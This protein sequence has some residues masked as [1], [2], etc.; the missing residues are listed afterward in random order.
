MN[1]TIQ[2]LEAKDSDFTEAKF[3][4]KVENEFVQIKLSTVTGK[5]EKVKH[6]VN[7]EIYN[8]IVA[9][10]EEDK[11]QN[12]IQLYEELNV[13]N[14][15]IIN[16]EEQEDCFTIEVRLLSKAYEYYINRETKKY[17]SGNTEERAEKFNKLIFTK[18][19]KA[20][21]FEAARKCP[22]CGAN[23]DVNKDGKCSYC[24]SIFDLSSYDWVITYMDI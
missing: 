24:G 23:I 3:K 10:V 19:K 2:E 22:S 17:I 15:Q 21:Q 6:F 20:K 16:I 9:K 11:N 5:T 1:I 7:D 4:S 14:I 13:A 18:I 8:K 12:R